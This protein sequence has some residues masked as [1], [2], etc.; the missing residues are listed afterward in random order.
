M[1]LMT[2][3]CP[4]RGVHGVSLS[5]VELPG[6]DLIFFNSNRNVVGDSSSQLVEMTDA[7]GHL[8]EIVP[9]GFLLLRQGNQTGT[10]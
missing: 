2:G 9:H 1:G 8:I 4:A 3:H 10:V 7:L 6:R 5:A